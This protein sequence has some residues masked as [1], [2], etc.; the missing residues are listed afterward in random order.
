MTPHSRPRN[1]LSDD[2]KRRIAAEMKTAYREDEEDGPSIRELADRFGLSY[3]VTYRLLVNV[4][5]VRLRTQGGK[6]RTGPINLPPP[7]P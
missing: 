4:A 7:G 5:G 3:S 6:P 1:H 2:D